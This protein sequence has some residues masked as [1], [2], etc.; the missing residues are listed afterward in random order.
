MNKGKSIYELDLHEC[1]LV[2]SDPDDD[3]TISVTRVPGGWNY[4]Y[5]NNNVLVAVEFV[6][7]SDEFKPKDN[8]Y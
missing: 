8:E 4:G 2:Y 3:L 5:W 7:Y 6:P 1:M